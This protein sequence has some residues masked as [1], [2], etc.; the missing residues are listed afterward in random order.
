MNEQKLLN[1]EKVCL[2]LGLCC[3]ICT[4]DGFGKPKPDYQIVSFRCDEEQEKQV[5]DIVKLSVEVQNKGSADPGTVL[6][7][8]GLQ[9]GV[10]IGIENG[11][12]IFDK[13]G[14]QG[15][16]NEFLYP[17]TSGGTI[18]WHATIDG[19]EAL[20]TT[21]VNGS[22]GPGVECLV[23]ADC[24][25]A[26]FCNGS[27]TCSAGVCQPGTAPVL[28]DAVACTDDSCDETGDVVVHT[29]N[30]AHCDNALFCDGTETCD[31]VSDC[32]PGIAPCLGG[33]DCDETADLCDDEPEDPPPPTP[34]GDNLVA[35]HDRSSPQYQEYCTDCHVDVHSRQSLDPSVPA[36]HVAMLPFAAGKVGQDE[37]CVWCHVTVD[38]TQ[39]MQSQGRYK[40]NLRRYT[41]SR[42][43]TLCHGPA[44]PGKQFYEVSLVDLQLDGPAQYDLL[45][46]ACHK[47]LSNTELRG[48]P[49]EQIQKVINEDK[50]GMG[51][52]TVLTWEQIQAIAAA[53]AE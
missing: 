23:D 34:L 11:V 10:T 6:T 4:P 2:L 19:D 35:A 42:L 38:L 31:A 46:A 3:L 18:I 27:E 44:G 43:C 36:A 39:G 7:L 45:C 14:K 52:Y 21:R 33:E 41:D 20:C 12:L 49:A 51:V 26:A 40:G 30:D 50:G 28:D 29:P 47:D 25:D 8:F 53:V 37:Q 17:I 9:E 24:D 13:R 32:Q 5:G 16:T 48:K 15:V 22:P 1:K